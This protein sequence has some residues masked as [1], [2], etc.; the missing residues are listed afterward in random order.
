MKY[1]I[2][3]LN[4]DL[5]FAK[6]RGKDMYDS[7]AP[8]SVQSPDD[9]PSNKINL[10]LLK[11]SIKNSSIIFPYNNRE[12][13]S[14]DFVTIGKD[15]VDREINVAIT[16][17][18]FVISP[19]PVSRFGIIGCMFPKYSTPDLDYYIRPYFG[20]DTGEKY[21]VTYVG[22]PKTKEGYDSLVKVLTEFAVYIKNIIGY[23]VKANFYERKSS[24]KED[25]KI[26][27]T[28]SIVAS[29]I[30]GGYLLFNK[31]ISDSLGNSL[32]A[33]GNFFSD[34]ILKGLT[35]YCKKDGGIVLSNVGPQSF[36]VNPNLYSSIQR[37]R[38]LKAGNE[39][40]PKAFI[41]F[42]KIA[43]LE[44][45]V[46][47]CYSDLHPITALA[48][49]IGHYKVSKH[50]FLGKI[51]DTM[52]LRKLS[53]NAGLVAFISFLFGIS[54]KEATA[55]LS[56]MVLQLPYLIP[57]F[58]ASWYGL[59]ILKEIGCTEEEIERAKKDFKT[60]YFTYLH[61]AVSLSSIGPA[62]SGIRNIIMS[63]KN[64]SIR[65]PRKITGLETLK[66]F[67]IPK[68]KPDLRKTVWKNVINK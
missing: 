1:N 6:Y 36:Y 42:A 18:G 41:D 50:W 14:S 35:D 19:F 12:Y 64:F 39:K 37:D 24:P 54:G 11:N 13:K 63:S 31:K 44:N 68:S 16:E 5:D 22:Y 59:R 61:K 67:K 58:A 20:S 27:K 48:H 29:A 4:S 2:K 34:K 10:N 28:F 3:R 52:I 9:I 55:F 30:G 45:K 43:L 56:A 57:E 60:A 7:F 32:A 23:R 47:I 15:S 21:I 66:N 65:I 33:S 38:I 53:R 51:Q 25:Q 62:V 46:L 26:E 8:K 17:R 49:E 40:T